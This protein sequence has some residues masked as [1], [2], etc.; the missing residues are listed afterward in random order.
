MEE[1]ETKILNQF[2][3]DFGF[4]RP[5]LEQTMRSETTLTFE[6]VFGCTRKDSQFYIWVFTPTLKHTQNVTFGE[7]IKF[8]R[9]FS[10]RHPNR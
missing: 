8:Y 3:V 9:H 4:Q 10:P 1:R 5:S 2:Y 6:A 7:F